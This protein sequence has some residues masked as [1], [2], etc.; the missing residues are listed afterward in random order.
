MRAY[1]SQWEWQF[2]LSQRWH[3]NMERHSM[4]TSSANLHPC[5]SMEHAWS[6]ERPC[7]VKIQSNRTRK[8]CSVF[9]AVDECALSN[10]KPLSICSITRCTRC[11]ITANIVVIVHTTNV[12]ADGISP[13]VALSMCYLVA[14]RRPATRC[15]DT[16]KYCKNHVSRY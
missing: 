6:M 11:A 5:Q 12:Q 14:R 1:D 13:L 10:G 16:K 9:A 7:E 3:S 4:A 2:N 15:G 8:S